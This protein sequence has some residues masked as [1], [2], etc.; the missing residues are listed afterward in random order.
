MEIFIREAL[1]SDI[2]S[3][4][5]CHKKIME[6]HINSDTRFTLREGVEQ[7]WYEQISDA[8]NNPDNLV[9]VTEYNS[10]L[11]GCSYTNIK[12]GAS[13]FGTQQIGYLF[14][15]FV[16]PRYRRKGIAGMFLSYSKK[17][18][19]E[20]D[21]HMIETSWSVHSEEALNTWPS[22]GFVPISISGQLEF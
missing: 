9:L 17:W 16:E 20:R 13:D 6:H 3:L 14:D 12:K 11:I 4:V 8:V 21:I 19:L 22:L 7:K 15:V 18:L 2:Q 1:D 10:L 5:I